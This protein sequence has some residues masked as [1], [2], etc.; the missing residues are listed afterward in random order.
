M[1]KYIQ[2]KL[3][4][5]DTYDTG[6]IPLEFAVVGKNIFTDADKMNWQVID[7]YNNSIKDVCHEGIDFFST[8]ATNN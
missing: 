7:V 2:C 3:K 4:N 5:A 1:T 8:M 6:Y